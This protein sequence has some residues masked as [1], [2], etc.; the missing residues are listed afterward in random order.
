MKTFIEKIND[1]NKFIKLN[2]INKF[3][4]AIILISTIISPFLILYNM[5]LISKFIDLS[6]INTNYNIYRLITL[7]ILIN[8]F[9]FV[10]NY[11][12]KY[13]TKK[14]INNI[15][16]N[17]RK[18]FFKKIQNIEFK[19]FEDKKRGELISI[20]NNNINK[21]NNL[22]FNLFQFFINS[23]Y[24]IFI[25]IYIGIISFKF[26]LIS[27]LILIL[28]ISLSNVL[29]KSLMELNKE[30]HKNYGII[31][32]ELDEV[33]NGSDV[34]KTFNLKQPII[35]ETDFLVLIIS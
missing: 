15:I 16:S 27:L 7:V 5:N 18:K 33:I 11:L 23:S 26:L 4:L 25:I 29:N 35:N 8:I 3:Y 1:L 24:S 20:F 10:N 19:T 34:I 12:N 22:I 21:I 9:D 13:Y 6:L 30:I 17:I 32:V 28:T 31:G 14:S 2:Y